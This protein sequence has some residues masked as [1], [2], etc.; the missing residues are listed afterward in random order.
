MTTFLLHLLGKLPFSI[1]SRIGAALGFLFGS[2]PLRDR[3]FAVE[4]IRRFL[5]PPN[6]T[7]VARSVFAHFGALA[8]ECCDLSP[9]LK[10]N[11]NAVRCDDLPLVRK[12]LEQK[13][14]IVA[15]TAHIG[16]WELLA[17]FMCRHG[18]PVVTVA[19]EARHAPFQA[20]LRE[21]RAALGI[22]TIWRGGT[23]AQ[24]SMVNSLLEGKTVAALIDQDTYVSGVGSTFFGH[25]VS[26][27]SS[28]IALAK[29]HEAKIVTAFCVR[30]KD[31]N[32]RA[33]VTEIPDEG[34]VKEVIDTF[35]SRL[36]HLIREYPEQWVWFHKRWRTQPDGARLSSSQYLEYLKNVPRA[37]SHPQ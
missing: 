18:V 20:F 37:H 31:G 26:T 4:Q 19:R 34:S 23:S 6:P 21:R 12:L 14:P 27:P 25:F 11:F 24:K 17:A 2:L 32:Y 22:E 3:N 36:E 5:N 16:N 9:A 10:T 33:S 28:L 7:H 35:N 8:L 15:L 30:E 1:R 13:K 29:R